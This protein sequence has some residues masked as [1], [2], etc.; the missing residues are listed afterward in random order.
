MFLAEKID[1]RACLAMGLVNRVVA[2]ERLREEAFALA[3]R[4]AHGPSIAFGFMKDTLNEALTSDF[5]TSLDNEAERMVRVTATDDHK[6]AVKAFVAK[7]PPVFTGS[8][9]VMGSS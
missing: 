3:R 5:L 1:A 8:Q 7:R 4:L 9:G 2:D 6:E